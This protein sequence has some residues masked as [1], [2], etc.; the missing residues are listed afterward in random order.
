MLE[1]HGRSDNGLP[2]S[3]LSVSVIYAINGTAGTC[4]TEVEPHLATP[5]WQ[6]D[7]TTEKQFLL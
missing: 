6:H 7:R 1:V 2:E 3:V 5:M 4:H